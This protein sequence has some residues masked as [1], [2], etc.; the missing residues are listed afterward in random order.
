MSLQPQN[1]YKVPAETARVARAIFPNGHPY[2]QWYDTFGVL[3]EDEDFK[4]L[5]PADCQPAWSPVRLSLVVILQFAEGFSDRQ[6]ADAVRSR[7]DPAGRGVQTRIGSTQR[8]WVD[9]KYA[10]SLE[11]TDPGFH[12]SVLSEFRDRLVAGGADQI[13]LERM[14][15][16]CQARGLLAGKDKQQTDSTH[17]VAA[18]RQ[19]N[20]LEL[21]GE[22]MRRALDDLV[23]VVP[24][25]LKPHI[26][27]E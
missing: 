3:F 18:I 12:Y 23:Q 21:V 4:D 7:I 8:S 19:L 10:L 15:E 14:L 25:W 5:Y 1:E 22:T 9:W 20:R 11:L 17:I 27:P 26:Q 16:Q 2:L 13:L 24:G 6:A